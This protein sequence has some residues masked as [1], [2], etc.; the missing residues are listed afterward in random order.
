MPGAASP[1]GNL[2]SGASAKDLA[3]LE[4]DDLAPAGKKP[5]T[6]ADSGGSKQVRGNPKPPGAV[7]AQNPGL[8]AIVRM[9]ASRAGVG[10]AEA[11]GVRARLTQP[12]PGGGSINPRSCIR[13]PP[14]T[15]QSQAS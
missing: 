15:S 8:H 6:A 9:R 5:R 2:R 4:D 7:A 1:A 10:S 13:I 11:G 12:W 14:D 3:V